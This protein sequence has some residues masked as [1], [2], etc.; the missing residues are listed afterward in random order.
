MWSIYLVAACLLYIF[1]VILGYPLMLSRLPARK[2][3]S[4]V[5]DNYEPSITAVIPVHNGAAFLAA[6]LDSVLASA[7]DPEKLEVL[8]ISDGSTDE[9][10]RI[11]E[12]Y[13]RTG[14]VRFVRLSRG[15][16]PAALNEA[17]ARTNREVLVMTDVRQR[18]EPDCIQRLIRRLHDPEVAVV[19]GNLLFMPAKSSEEVNIGL[20]WKYESWIRSHLSRHD[21]LLGATGP[22]YAIRRELTS[23]LPPSSL[24]DDVWLPMQAVL[25]GFRSVWEKDAV[26]WDYPTALKTEFTRKVRTQAGIYQLLRQEPRL[27]RPVNRLR[28]HF[29]SYKLG[30]LFLPHVML[31]LLAASL[32]LPG[33]AGVCALTAEFGFYGLAA[34][35]LLIAD[36]NPLKRLTGPA[37]AIPGL[38]AAAFC[39]Q[40]IFLVEPGRLWKVTYAPAANCKGDDGPR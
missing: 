22:I 13:T 35:D 23:P 36:G 40:A 21:S 34:L 19:S 12:S 32:W 39:A 9:T 6:K 8:V 16:K 1:W 18:L 24:L 38:V 11:A 30:R 20:Y 17:L 4:A 29:I 26:V 10:D 14:R 37:R 31:I 33:R 5:A 27:L 15:G 28:W 25:K 2:S 3:Q 7:W